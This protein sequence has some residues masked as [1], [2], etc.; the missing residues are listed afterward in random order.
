M[1]PL[2]SLTPARRAVAA[3]R[4]PATHDRSRVPPATSASRTTIAGLALE[5]V[6]CS[7]ATGFRATSW[8]SVG[9]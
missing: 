5:A 7:A 8:H 3:D 4:R 9:R 6:T 2:R 1:R